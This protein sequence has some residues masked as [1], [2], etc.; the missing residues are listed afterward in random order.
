MLN[1][2]KHLCN[3]VISSNCHE[4]TNVNVF[5]I[6]NVWEDAVRWLRMLS[7]CSPRLLLVDSSPCAMSPQSGVITPLLPFI[8]RLPPSG[9][10]WAFTFSAAGRVIRDTG[11]CWVRLIHLDWEPF[12]SYG[13]VC[14]TLGEWK[15]G[16]YYNRCVLSLMFVL[17]YS[18]VEMS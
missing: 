7:R 3:L 4:W 15:K 12:M 2:D 17:R 10:S 9:P 14:C 11:M 6:S 16:V 8:P 18:R 13:T 5:I 1:P